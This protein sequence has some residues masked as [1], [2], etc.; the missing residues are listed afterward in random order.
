MEE[1]KTVIGDESGEK[2]DKTEEVINAEKKEEIKTEDKEVTKTEN[3]DE[4]KIEIKTDSESDD[5]ENNK[6]DNKSETKSEDKTENKEKS[7]IKS[8]KKIETEVKVKN[9]DKSENEE[10]TV[11]KVVN[12]ASKKAI[13]K[14]IVIAGCASGFALLM[15]FGALIFITK[16][17]EKYFDKGTLVNGINVGNMTVDEAKKK[18]EDFENNYQLAVEFE[19]ETKIIKGVSINFN[20]TSDKSVENCLK[21][22][23]D[24]GFFFKLFSKGKKE[25]DLP[26][27]FDEKKFRM[28]LSN[29]DELDTAKMIAPED[30]TYYIDEGQY[31]VKEEVEGNTLDVKVVKEA[32]K[33]AISESDKEINMED[34]YERPTVHA[35][36][37]NLNSE[38]DVLNGLIGIQVVYNLPKGKTKVLDGDTLVKW[39]SIDDEGNYYKDTNRWNRK[40]KKYVEKLAE[41]Y[42]TVYSE[43]KFHTTGG[44]DVMLPSDGYYGYK[45]DVE[46]EIEQLKKDLNG[47]ENVEREPIYEKTEAASYDDNY[48]FGDSYIEISIEEQHLWLYIDGKV[49]VETDVVTGTPDGKHYTSTGAFTAFDKQTNKKLTGE[50]QSNG[51]PE[52][53]VRVKNWIRVTNY[54]IGIH[55]TSYRS[56]YGGDIWKTNGSHGCINCPTRIMPEIYKLAYNG[57]PI[58]IY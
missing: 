29:Y 28:L 3:K 34:F 12:A 24:G 53:V 8:D 23:N 51:R 32:I 20:C 13:K 33:K 1:K 19:D 4:V 39:L 35:D 46:A 45:I 2:K 25:F 49:E 30:A 16:S 21:K 55:E 47:N 17:N 26:Y 22:Q 18:L 31:K 9:E 6:V 27:S 15:F 54:G 37:E 57:M 42:D 5:K 41:K 10:V 40:L 14:K 50:I 48:G 11:T 38:V 56:R 44:E 36:D 52:Y 43:H 58:A 7:E